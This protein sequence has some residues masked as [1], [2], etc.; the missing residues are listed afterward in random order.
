MISASGGLRGQPVHSSFIT[1][2]NRLPFERLACMT[3]GA[4]LAVAAFAPHCKA[5]CFGLDINQQM[6]CYRQENQIRE[7]QRQ[8]RDMEQQQRNM[9]LQ[10]IGRPSNFYGQYPMPRIGVPNRYF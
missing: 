1:T 2:M 7:L 6:D 10:Q 5:A 9:E 8:Q 4:M 3:F